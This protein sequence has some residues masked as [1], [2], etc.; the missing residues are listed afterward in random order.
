MFCRPPGTP[1]VAFF[2][3]H[4]EQK[5]EQN[6]HGQGPAHGVHMHSHEA[7]ISGFLAGMGHGP[8]GFLQNRA[9]STF[10]AG[11]ELAVGE[12]SQVV[13]YIFYWGISCHTALVQSSPW[14]WPD[15]PAQHATNH[16][17]HSK[18]E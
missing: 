18:S 8:L 6:T 7:H 1:V 13:L 2:G 4:A 11:R 3:H 9:V 12:V 10:I 16:N 14:L 15:Q 17:H 5:Q